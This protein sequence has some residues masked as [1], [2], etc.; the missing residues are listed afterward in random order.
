VSGIV[1]IVNTDGA[2][3]NVERLRELT[4]A[5]AFRGPDGNAMQSC[6]E[7]GF[8][9][10]LFRT[11]D[12]SATECQPLSLDGTVWIVADCRVDDRATLITALGEAGE[13]PQSDAPD[14]ELILRAYLTWGARCVERLLGDFAFV[15][16]DG[17]THT[18]FAARDH[19]G[20]KPFF[21]AHVGSH[22]IVSN[23]LGCIRRHPGVPAEVN[24]AAIGDFL[25]F[26]QSFY[27]GITAF[28]HVQR[29]PAAH[30]L[31]CC[32]GDVRIERYWQVP[33]YEESLRLRRGEIVER[34]RDVLRAAVSDRLRARAAAVLL[35]GGVDSTCVAATAF[36][37]KRRNSLDV[38]LT[39]WTFDARPLVP[40]DQECDLA[41]LTAAA[42]GF[43]HVRYSFEGYSLFRDAAGRCVLPRPEPH[44]LSFAAPLI[45]TANAI[46][47]SCRVRLT[48]QGGGGVFRAQTLRVRDLLPPSRWLTIAR[49]T[50]GY[51]LRY[52]A[53]PPLGIRTAIRRLAG[54]SRRSAPSFP[55]WIEP[56]FAQRLGLRDRWQELLVHRRETPGN[57]LRPSAT[58]ELREPWANILEP[59]D[60]EWSGAPLDTRHPLLDLR[61]VDFL[62]QLPVVPWFWNRDLPRRTYLGPIPPQ[63]RNRRKAPETGNPVRAALERGHQLPNW[64]TQPA[65]RNYV[66][67]ERVPKAPSSAPPID[68]ASQRSAT[69]PISLSIWLQSLTR[70]DSYEQQARSPSAVSQGTVTT[71]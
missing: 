45:D 40:D 68:A 24:E 15:I 42:L 41:R 3:C 50:V 71:G 60:V 65:L 38:S 47:N 55:S 1:A 33:D 26:G 6:D 21:Y 30:T 8:G 28:R 16:W 58:H 59:Y 13:Q 31:R 36:D 27:P 18:L 64:Q 63:I 10:A 11:T 48:G 14:I 2:P 35:S 19:F 29:L 53:P 49:D 62:L 7:A 37:L 17:R 39:A 67:C 22:L 70:G 25:L 9:A 57:V 44:D 12:E 56:E 66:R 5:L 23:T 52:R 61:L 20:V 34:F 54:I 69:Y 43:R 51:A 46:A 4:Q 32:D